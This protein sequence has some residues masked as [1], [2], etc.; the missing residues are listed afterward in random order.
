MPRRPGPLSPGAAEVV[1][2]LEERQTQVVEVDASGPVELLTP[3]GVPIGTVWA[4][5]GGAPSRSST[6]VKVQLL[7]GVS[8]VEFVKTKRR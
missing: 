3:E 5:V 2:R 1:S 4:S 8:S 6:P 7:P